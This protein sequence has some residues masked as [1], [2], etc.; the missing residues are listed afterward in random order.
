LK[1]RRVLATQFEGDALVFRLEFSA[2]GAAMKLRNVT[3][4]T[5]TETL[6]SEAYRAMKDAP[7]T[8][9]VRVE[10]KKR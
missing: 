6:V 8:L 3:P 1:R 7:E 2:G 9:P 10:A 4:V 5:G